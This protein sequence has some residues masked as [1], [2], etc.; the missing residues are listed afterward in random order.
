MKRLGL[1]AILSSVG[2]VYACSGVEPVTD[3]TT[4]GASAASGVGGG[5]G[6][7]TGGTT[8]GSIGAGS[9]GMAGTST[10]GG[11]GGTLGGTSGTAGSMSGAGGTPAL[12]G[13]SG[14]AGAGGSITPMGGM[15]GAGGSTAGDAGAG[16]SITPIG[17]MSG[18]GGSAGSGTS[19]AGGGAGSGMSGAGGGGSS[20]PTVAELFPTGPNNLGSLDG[21]L[22]T[23]PCADT[24]SDDC[25]G[26]GWVYNGVTSPCQNNQLT[27]QQDFVVGGTPGQ[28]YMVTIHFYGIV[29]PKNYGGQ[30]TRES[31]N[32]RPTNNNN[33]ATPVPWAYT[34]SAG[35]KNITPSDYNT[36]E[37]HVMDE[38]M[39]VDR[40][41]FLNSDTNEGHWTYVLDYE[42]TIPV[43]GGGRVRFRT[44]DSNCRMIKNCYDGGQGSAS[45]CA[46]RARSI[47]TVTNAMPPPTGL[48]Q[49]GLGNEDSQSGQWVYTDVVSVACP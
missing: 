48:M 18:T 11:A 32:T 49:P 20:C 14:A 19:G 17:G 22:V 13:S 2:A 31:G 7:T 3:T 43:I 33:G 45:Q 23:T 12:G 28:T 26:G 5:S 9:G 39:Q 21:R 25:N 37:L 4:G 30:V 27:A 16:G 24:S 35:A 6:G 40:Q 10:V 34:T 41:Y 42:K 15:S 36:Y 44:F 8:G 1:F 29:E 47:S 38:N 46:D